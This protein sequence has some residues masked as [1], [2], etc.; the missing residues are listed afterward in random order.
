MILPLFKTANLEASAP[1]KYIAVI[2]EQND[3]LWKI[4]QHYNQGQS[5]LRRFINLIQ[6][7]NNLQSTQIYPGQIIEIPL[8]K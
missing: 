5:D 6:K 2:V 1:E 7:H 4:A 8:S 3:S